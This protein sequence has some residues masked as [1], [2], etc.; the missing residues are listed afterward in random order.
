M[1]STLIVTIIVS[2]ASNQ[3]IRMITEGSAEIEDW[4]KKISFAITGINC[5]LKYIKIENGFCFYSVSDQIDLVSIRL[6]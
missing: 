5:L 2:S 3:H 1:F 4:S 6:L